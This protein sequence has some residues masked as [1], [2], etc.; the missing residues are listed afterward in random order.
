[1]RVVY[2]E[3]MPAVAQFLGHCCDLVAV[4]GRRLKAP[5]LHGADAL[6]VRSVTRVDADLLAESTLRFVGSATSG[7]EHVDRQLLA[8]RDIRFLHAPGANANSVVEYVLSA[9]AAVDTTLE[10]LLD[11]AR[12]GIVGYGHVGRQLAR[13]CSALGIDWCASDPWLPGETIARAAPLEAV[14]RSDVICLHPAL[15]RREPWP[16]FH[17]LGESQLASLGPGQLLINASRGAVVDNAALLDRLSSARS[18][19]VVLDVWEHEPEVNA[20]LLGKVRLGT[21]HIA[22]YSLDA[23][24]AA[25]RLL[26]EALGEAFDLPIPAGDAAGLAAPVLTLGASSAAEG[27]R[28]LLGQRYCIVDDDRRLREVVSAGNA[29]GA[30]FDGLR[31]HYPERREVAGSRVRVLGGDPAMGRLALALGA[32]PEQGAA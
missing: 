21:A 20:E 23:K 12:L 26:A 31:R 9:I 6:L 14:L 19:A 2:D 22:G 27:I 16:S 18:P 28:A 29:T 30:G 1:M 11:G 17:L 15:T 25:T 10:Q 5:Q 4:D 13:R 32:E 24:I 8:Q 3:N 7:L